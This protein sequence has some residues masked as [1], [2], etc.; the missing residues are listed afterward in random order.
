MWLYQVCSAVLP[1]HSC[2]RS[3]RLALR[4]SPSAKPNAGLLLPALPAGPGLRPVRGG[5]QQ[6]LRQTGMAVFQVYFYR[7]VLCEFGANV[8]RLCLG[9]LVTSAGMFVASSAFLPSTTSLYLTLLS[10]G[11]W[12]HQRYKLAIFFTALSTFLS[13]FRT[14]ILDQ[15]NVKGVDTC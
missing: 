5:R 14:L 13:K 1:L 10:V 8:G 11:A 3:A 6:Q 15:M 7:G 4:P 12:F 2:A 9:L